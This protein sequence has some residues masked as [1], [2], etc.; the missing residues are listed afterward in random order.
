MFFQGSVNTA[1]VLVWHKAKSHAPASR[2]VVVE[3]TKQD[4]LARAASSLTREGNRQ[5][6]LV[7]AV[8]FMSVRACSGIGFWPA[9][10]KFYFIQR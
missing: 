1:L 9:T 2:G 6:S 7:L 3:V 10:D 5:G 4:S 8:L